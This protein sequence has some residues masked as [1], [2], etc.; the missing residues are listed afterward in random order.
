MNRSILSRLLWII[1][2]LKIKAL[3][4]M[5]KIMKTV[6]WDMQGVPLLNLTHHNAIMNAS[7]YQAT[8]KKLKKTL[9]QSAS[10]I[11][12]K[13]GGGVCCCCMTIPIHTKS[14]HKEYLE[15]QE[16]FKHP[17]YS[18]DLDLVNSISLQLHKR[19]CIV[20]WSKPMIMSSMKFKNGC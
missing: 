13:G 6:F 20:I 14:W 5:G 7:T 9:T 10:Y 2:K 16:I 15:K 11:S 19:T 17:T 12:Q 18:T 8:L 4:R 1:K 3:N